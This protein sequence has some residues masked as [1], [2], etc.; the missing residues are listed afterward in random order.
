MSSILWIANGIKN[1]PSF[2][3]QSA[4]KIRS[5]MSISSL[6]LSALRGSWDA[7]WQLQIIAIGSEVFQSNCLGCFPIY[8]MCLPSLSRLCI[9]ALIHAS[10]L[11]VFGKSLDS[12][13]ITTPW[14]LAW[15]PFLVSVFPA[16]SEGKHPHWLECSPP[17]S[18]FTCCP[19]YLPPGP[20]LPF[21]SPYTSPRVH[22][23][24]KILI[25]ISQR[26]IFLCLL[27]KEYC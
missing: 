14:F 25:R 8:V 12:C 20:P 6:A 22:V 10:G 2:C 17:L 5:V 26:L 7:I 16:H 4:N 24:G 1:F 18:A 9:P 3:D 21:P 23:G 19:F 27:G 11:F 13:R 15:S